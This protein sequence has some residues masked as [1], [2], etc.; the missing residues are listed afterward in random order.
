VDIPNYPR[1]IHVSI[2]L[3]RG[4][5]QKAASAQ[6]F[7]F[8]VRTYD[9]DGGIFYNQY[10][11]QCNVTLTIA[12]G[13]CVLQKSQLKGLTGHFG[14]DFIFLGTPKDLCNR[15]SVHLLGKI[16][17]IIQDVLL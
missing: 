16:L 10:L 7:A 2:L 12:R 3:L 15:D 1:Y 17:T 6:L 8:G 14:E 9:A 13:T 5:R 4:D 11:P